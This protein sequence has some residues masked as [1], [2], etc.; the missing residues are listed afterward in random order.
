MY[1]AP[2]NDK[3]MTALGSAINDNREETRRRFPRR[4]EDTCIAAVDGINHPVQNWSECGVLFDA[5]GRDFEA[6]TTHDV[7][8]KFKLSDIVTEIPVQAKVVRAGRS[9]VAMEFGDLPRKIS[10]AF[11]K[12]IEE[13]LI[14]R[15]SAEMFPA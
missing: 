11:S 3:V 8:M 4:F 7:V 2:M 15:K 10:E 9:K 5:D 12:V 13:S 6:G 14:L 1:N